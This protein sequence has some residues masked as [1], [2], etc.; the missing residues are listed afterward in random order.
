MKETKVNNVE[1]Y[2]MTHD[3]ILVKPMDKSINDSTGLIDPEQYEDKAE[4]GEVL[5]VG[6]GRILEHGDIA[7][8]SVEK[9]DT[10]LF[11]KYSSYKIR[12]DGIDYLI[13]RDDD[14]MCKI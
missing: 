3:S 1:E 10:I 4:W 13:I 9:G 8:M 12:I 14:V 5:S 2:T 7:P 11:G 6:G